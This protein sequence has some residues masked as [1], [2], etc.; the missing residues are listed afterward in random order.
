MVI[1]AARPTIAAGAVAT[2]IDIAATGTIETTGAGT[3]AITV[4]A[5]MIAGAADV[6]ATA[7]D[8]AIAK[9]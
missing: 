7:T 8:G 3:T 9:D 5:T 2:V 1:S 4:I 6:I